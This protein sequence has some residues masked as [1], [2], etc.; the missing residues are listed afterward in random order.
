MNTTHWSTTEGGG[1][2]GE[3]INQDA[4]P[5][6]FTAHF[7]LQQE[8]TSTHVTPAAPPLVTPPTVLAPLLHQGRKLPRG[9]WWQGGWTNKRGVWVVAVRKGSPADRA[10]I[11][12]GDQ[13][14]KV[15]DDGR[16]LKN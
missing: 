7:P 11:E 16:G 13:L 5:A 12:Q 3:R 8:W 1:E 10:G 14:L 9:H 6:V 2:M 4:Q 15:R